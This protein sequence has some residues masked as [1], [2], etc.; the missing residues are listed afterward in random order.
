VSDAAGRRLRVAA[1][2]VLACCIGGIFA[3]D[4]VVASI[5]AGDATQSN[6]FFR[7]YAVNEPPF[8]WLLGAFAA[9]VWLVAR[10][11]GSVGAPL[12]RP[13][14]KSVAAPA[15]LTTVAVAGVAAAGALVV[16]HATRAPAVLVNPILAA[17]AV[18]S[19]AGASTRL[20]PGDVRRG[21]MAILYL[22]TSTQFLLVSMTPHAWAAHLSFNLL[23][24][25]LVLR[26]DRAGLAA[27]PW[28]G[29]AALGLQSPLPHAL[30]AAPFLLRLLRTRRVGWIAYYCA[31]YGVGALALHERMPLAI[32][33]AGP[34]GALGLLSQAGADRYVAAGLDLPLLLTWQAPAMALFL[35]VA[36]I[37]VRSLKPAER[38]LLAGLVLTFAFYALFGE[39]DGHDWGYRHIYPVLGSAALLAGSA[40]VTVAGQRGGALVSRL[41]MVS[42]AVAL[43]VQ[44]PL[45]AVRAER[46]AR[47]RAAAPPLLDT[48]AAARSTAAP[49]STVRRPQRLR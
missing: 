33:S 46:A 16:M 48:P 40:T 11:W 38:D 28:V 10:R 3:C 6:G 39:R 8:L 30:F 29:V 31:V 34:G 36:M 4:F 7:L 26:D 22:A 49:R 2:V 43:L 20:W 44:L 32:A 18:L 47:P 12:Q 15:L 24:L 45:R 14:T 37:V 17:I 1:L 13:A 9:L 42:V 21:R 25:Y 19:L 41:V 5:G 35:V 23:W 27:A